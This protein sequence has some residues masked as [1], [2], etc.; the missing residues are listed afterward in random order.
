MAYSY[1][2]YYDEVLADAIAAMAD[3]GDQCTDF[4]DF[5]DEV[6]LD[7]SVT[8]NGSGSYFFNSAKAKEAISDFIWSDEFVEMCEEFGD[9]VGHCMKMG[10]EGVDVSIRC[11]MLGQVSGEL[12][13]KWNEVFGDE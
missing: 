5:Y 10:P 9:T 2:D 13:D 11:W 8:G 4:Q 1:S 7:D 6:W 12:E 3:Y